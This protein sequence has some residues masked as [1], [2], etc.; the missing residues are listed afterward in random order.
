MPA[1]SLRALAPLIIAVCVAAPFRDAAGQDGHT[2]VSYVN[3]MIGTGGHG[4]TSPGA[5]IPFGMIQPGP[6]A[7]KSG[8]DWCSGY[9]YSDSSLAGFGHTHLSGTGCGD[10]GDILFVPGTSSRILAKG[11][12]APFSHKEERASPGYYAVRLLD[13]R[14]LVELT[15]TC[16]AAFH[17]YTFPAGDSAR[18]AIKLGYGQDDIT[19]SALCGL[20]GDSVL[21]GY[22]LSNGWA[23]NQRVYFAAR[24]SRA[25]R[26]ISYFDEGTPLPRVPVARGRSVTAVL[27]FAV[28]SGGTLLMKVGISAVS[29]AGALENL[30]AEIRGWEFDDVREQAA[31]AWEI[32]LGRVQV[33]G[34]ERVKSVLYTA[35]YHAML[36][37][38]LFGDVDGRYRGGDDSIHHAHDFDNYSTFSLWDTFRAAHPLYTIIDPDRIA[39]MV[40]A[41]LAF[42]RESGFLPVWPLAGNETNTM[43]GYHAVP[44]IADAIRKG[45]GGFDAREAF[46]AMKKSALRNHRGLQYYA[47]WV[48]RFPSAVASAGTATTA[49]AVVLNAYKRSLSGD[50]LSYHSALPAVTRALIVRADG[51]TP[52]IEWA[53]A[54]VPAGATGCSFAWHAGMAAGKGA[55]RFEFSINGTRVAEFTTAPSSSRTGW[56][57][58]GEKGVTLS[59]RASTADWFGDLFGTMVVTIPRGLVKPGSVPKFR[60]SAEQAGSPDWFMTFTHPFVPGMSLSNEFGTVREEGRVSQ[61]VRVDIQHIGSSVNATLEAGGEGPVPVMVNPGVTS[62][63][64]RVPPVTADTPVRVRL[65]SGT[66]ELRSGSLTVRPI[67]PIGYIPADKEPESVSKTL[68][69]AYDDWCIAQVARALGDTVDTALFTARSGYFRNVYD[70]STGF[71]RGKNLD[72]SWRTP[73]DPRFSTQKQPEY[74]EGNAWQYS[75]FVPH[76]VEGLIS[77]MGGRDLFTARLDSLFNQSSD[78]EGTGAPADVSGLIGMYAHGNEPS[79]HI[80]YLYALAGKPWK[81]QELVRRI[82]RTMYAPAPDGLCGNEDCGQMSAW[83]VLSALGFYPVN[84]AGGLYII[85]SPAVESAVLDVGGGRSFTVRATNMSDGNVYVQS[86]TLNGTSMDRVYLRHEEIMAGGT[87]EFVLG[88]APNTRWG[89]SIDSVPSSTSK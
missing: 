55:H 36:A 76:D 68:E 25:L 44:V 2:A 29:S 31:D 32:L 6:D 87:L 56:S 53:S 28:P 15:A 30:D 50:T 58:R 8:W 89:S 34:T 73:F 42:S 9:H 52:P 37:P 70:R 86:V 84:P 35:L 19:T 26:S 11:Y 85:G 69:Y 66:R 16:R 75:W 4:H 49:S 21:V 65:V 40:R 3:P 48:V 33:R 81:T 46:E 59:F 38:T 41:M 1:R 79:H 61:L 67:H 20:Q 17:R 5:S 27:R 18:V 54:P 78:L 88:A 82:L 7:G 64:L 47:P 57:V 23:P 74:T 12:R 80:A 77:L 71:M 39:H 72:G 45:I 13:S 63:W 10:L 22:R 51:K 60:V 14:V 83:Y 43:I 24:F 62:V